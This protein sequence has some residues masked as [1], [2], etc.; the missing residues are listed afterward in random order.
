MPSPVWPRR[1]GVVA[2]C[3]LACLVAYT[4]RVNISVAAVAMKEELHWSQTEKGF[5]LSAFFVGYMAFMIAAG[6]LAA[7]YGGRRVLGAAV[8]AW[9]AFTLLTPAAARAG[10]GALIAARVAMG[11]GEAA[12]FPAVVELYTRWVPV[13][14]RGRA[15]ARVLTG[16]PMGTVAGLLGAGWIVGRAHW[17]V[18]FYAFGAVGVVWA[19]AWF[20]RVRNDPRQDPHV[21]AEERALL[22][23]LGGGETDATRPATPVWKLLRHGRVWAYFAAYFATT[24]VLY[25]LVSWLPSYFRD[26]QGMSIGGAGLVSAAP[27]LSMAVVTNVAGVAADRMLRRGASLT[28][29]RKQLQAIA[30]LGS[31]AFLVAARDA[32]SPALALALLCGAAGTL[33]CA[34]SG[35]A[36]NA[37]DVAPRQAAVLTG[38]GNTFATIPGI[39]GV[40]VTGW[41]VEVTGTYA[42][43]FVLTAAVAGAGAVV[44]LL[45][46]DARPLAD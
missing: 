19:V 9:S 13:G 22:A 2:L 6:W 35:F 18:V 39:V 31:A 33:G 42:A 4:D 45:V 43:A 23:E 36:P 15:M 38:I 17:S 46:F 28:A 34:W 29:T 26:V 5:V 27:W 21:G 44:Y 3:F 32:H 40:S 37:L 8:L 24:W 20:A 11:V 41:L 25:V 14:E 12:M 16:I 7:R 30:L 1:H 10:F